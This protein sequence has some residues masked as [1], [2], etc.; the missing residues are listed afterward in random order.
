[1]VMRAEMLMSLNRLFDYLLLRLNNGLELRRS[2]AC[3]LIHL[4]NCSLVKRLMR[5]KG[6]IIVYGRIMFSCFDRSRLIFGGN[7]RL[8]IVI[9]PWRRRRNGLRSG[10]AFDGCC[11][12]VVQMPF[13]FSCQILCRQGG[14]LTTSNGL[15]EMSR[16]PLMISMGRRKRLNL[17]LQRANL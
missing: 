13:L 15:S 6:R 2:F 1:M 3:K 17:I 5:H 4:F 10:L 16:A 14:R 11:C 7:G 12:S 9:E 8:G